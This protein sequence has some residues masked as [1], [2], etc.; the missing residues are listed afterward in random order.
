MKTRHT[1]N[2]PKYLHNFNITD[3]TPKLKDPEANALL[4]KNLKKNAVSFELHGVNISI[5]NAFRRVLTSEYPTKIMHFDY[6]DF[7]TNDPFITNDFVQTRVRSIP[8]S[9]STTINQIFKLD[10]TNHSLLNQR[11]TSNDIVTDKNEHTS[12]FNE[13]FDLAVLSSNKYMKIKRIYVKE[14]FGYNHGC[15]LIAY[16]ATSIPLDVDMYNEFNPKPSQVFSSVSN[17]QKHKI[18]FKTNGNINIKHTLQQC[19]SILISRLEN[20]KSLISTIQSVVDLHTLSIN[21]E[22][23]TIGNMLLM[24]IVHSYP[25][26]PACTYDVNPLSKI[27]ILKIRNKDAIDHIISN[28]VDL[29]INLLS[30]IQSEFN[31]L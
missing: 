26:L 25:D 14:D 24:G 18:S 8:I 10:V 1:P 30:A 23:D 17:P 19:C 29:H 6:D 5:S 20:V 2:T 4:P 15:H 28:I 27:M 9:Q 12:L 22:T 3:I 11:V 16:H 31:S 7:E 21:G 13:S